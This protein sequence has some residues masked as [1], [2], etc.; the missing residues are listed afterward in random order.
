VLGCWAELRR[1]GRP[2]FGQAGGEPSGGW[3]RLARAWLLV[4]VGIV[5]VLTATGLPT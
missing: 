5:A 2:E 1:G 4:V 3:P